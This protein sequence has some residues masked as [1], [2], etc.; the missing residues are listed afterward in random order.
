MGYHLKEIK[1]GVFGEFSKIREECE[2]LEDAVAQDNPVLQL[3]ELSDMLG[4]IEAYVARFNLTLD[5]LSKMKEATKRA[6]QSGH[7]K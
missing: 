6:F 4:A 2:E 7:R 3:V 1:R 5:D